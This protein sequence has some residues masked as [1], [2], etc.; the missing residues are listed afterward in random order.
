MALPVD[1]FCIRMGDP[2]VLVRQ[3]REFPRDY[4]YM[5][6]EIKGL[7]YRMAVCSTDKEIDTRL[8]TELIL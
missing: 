7:P 5:E 6:Y 1:A 8:H 3:P 2:P 4:Y